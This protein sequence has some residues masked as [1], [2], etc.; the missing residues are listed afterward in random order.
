MK[1]SNTSTICNLPSKIFI[2]ASYV[3]QHLGLLGVF[4]RVG[5]LESSKF[6]YLIAYRVIIVSEE[7]CHIYGFI[8]IFVNFG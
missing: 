6:G 8:A 7:V 2:F 5:Y 1:H 4:L 3:V